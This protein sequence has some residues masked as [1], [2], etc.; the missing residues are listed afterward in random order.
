MAR[1]LAQ[2]CLVVGGVAMVAGVGYAINGAT[3]AEGDVVVS[4]SARSGAVLEAPGTTADG[5]EA[6]VVVQRSHLD[7]GALGVD[8]PGVGGTNRLEVHTDPLTLRS[9][10]STVAEQVLNRGG[11]AVV[12]VCVGL[13]AVLLRRLL[14]SIA[15]GRPFEPGNAARIAGIAGLVV[16]GSLSSD[17]LP[18]LGTNLVLERIG[19]AGAES[20]IVASPR[21]SL[22]PLLV[23]PLLLA[24]AEA[25]RHGTQLAQ[26]VDGLT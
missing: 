15:E 19:R 22:V 25:F 20:P 11:I 12:A 8:I 4:V 16:I 17:L 18:R 14:L 6:T 1:L 7:G 24:L 10:D 2:A 5:T 3:R 9:W 13:G 26:D 21:F 23:A